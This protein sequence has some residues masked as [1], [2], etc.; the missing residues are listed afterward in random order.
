MG[1][2]NSLRWHISSLAPQ[3][4][5]KITFEAM[6]LPTAAGQ[7]TITNTASL[8]AT[9][10]GATVRAEDDAITQVLMKLFTER[11]MLLG[12]S[13]IDENGNNRLDAGDTPVEG[14][15]LYLSNGYSFV[16]DSRGRYVF[17]NLKA[18]AMA[19]RADPLTLPPLSMKMAST[20]PAAGLWR[21]RL[22]PGVVTQQDVVFEP[23]I[24]SVSQTQTLNVVQGPVRVSKELISQGE[25]E[26]R[27]EVTILS[28]KPVDN[29]I[30]QDVLPPGATLKTLPT[31]ALTGAERGTK[32]LTMSLG[33]LAE[34]VVTK[35][36][37]SFRYTPSNAAPTPIT[38]TPVIKW[39]MQ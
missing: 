12:T 31:D 28:D 39:G 11:S 17:Q 24:L 35:L 5:F 38:T 10:G 2:D 36:S 34:N 18:G 3:G 23:A 26:Y 33:S 29:V 1:S 7:S 37:Y 14:L 27:V 13:Y 16:T 22:L 19:M 9:D 15:R 21:L 32:D 8:S 6:V 25:G 30:V 20:N 4:S